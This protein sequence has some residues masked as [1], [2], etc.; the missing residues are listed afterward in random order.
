MRTITHPSDEGKSH[1]VTETTWQDQKILAKSLPMDRPNAVAIPCSFA[2]P[3]SCQPTSRNSLLSSRAPNSV[4]FSRALNSPLSSRALNSLLSS[5]APNSLP[6]SRAPNKKR[7][8]DE[9]IDWQLSVRLNNTSASQQVTFD[10]PVFKTERSSPEYREDVSIDAPYLVPVD[11]NA[12]LVSIPL[13]IEYLASR[14]R[15]RFS[16][17][18]KRDFFLLLAF[19]LALSLGMWAIFRYVPTGIAWIVAILPA[20]LAALSYVALVRVLT[21]KADIEITA[22][23]TTFT[24]GFVWSRRRYEFP[25]GIH[26]VLECYGEDRRESGTM[27]SVRL[28]PEDGPPC[29]VIKRLDGKQNAFAVR[30]WLI[31]QLLAKDSAQDS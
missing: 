31:K 15:L 11:T 2:I 27:Y 3:Y 22:D 14:E 28:V 13:K 30:D 1:S 23:M 7:D 16:L 24:A 6:S 21:W 20:F 29:D 17:L 4:P 19:A 10:I 5:R 9:S 12:V 18:R 26:P 25:R 8:Y